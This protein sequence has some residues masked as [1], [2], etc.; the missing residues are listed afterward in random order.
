MIELFSG[1]RNLLT[2][3]S[4]PNDEVC[5][6]SCIEGIMG[7]AWVN[8]IIEPLY[9]IVAVADF[10]F[11]LGQVPEVFSVELINIIETHGKNQIIVSENPEWENGIM[12]AIPLNIVRF[13]RYSFHREPDIFDKKRLSDFAQGKDDGYDVIPFTIEIAE[14]AKLSSF[15]A[16]FC[17]FFES[18]KAFLKQGIGFCIIQDD[19]IVAGAS[20]YS[21]C[22]GAIDITIG[23]IN[24]YRRKGLAI[25]CASRLILACLENGIYPRWDAANLES[26][27]LAE[28]LGYRFKE[29]YQVFTI[30]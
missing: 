12:K 3:F 8:E 22:D 15:T 10:L 4:I 6:W 9:G 17:M 7:R 30:K 16:D 29:T 24:E 13:K 25:K 23:T 28:K 19:Q 2:K 5:I 27:A 18:P 14:K 20:S 1:E 26:V 11:L 21:A